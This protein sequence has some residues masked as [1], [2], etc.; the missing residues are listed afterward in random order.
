MKFDN[1]FW[2]RFEGC[3][4]KDVYM[5]FSLRQIIDI[6]EQKRSDYT[7]YVF[8]KSKMTDD[9]EH[10]LPEYDNIRWKYI[11]NDIKMYGYGKCLDIIRER[12]E[13]SYNN[14]RKF[15]NETDSKEYAKL[16]AI[17]DAE[18]YGRRWID[19]EVRSGKVKE[20]F[21]EYYKFYV[22]MVEY[23]SGRNYGRYKI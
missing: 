1:G 6:E 7:Y 19:V 22:E 9:F 5:L 2:K 11:Q 15:L 14:L 12:L 21:P 23:M 18:K 20:R 16:C 8:H 10:L 17:L 13:K 4:D 3:D